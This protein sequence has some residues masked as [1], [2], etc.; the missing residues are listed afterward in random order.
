MVEVAKKDLVVRLVGT[1]AVN[2]AQAAQ[3]GVTGA[4]LVVGQ[5]YGR[6][7]TERL[8]PT[9]HVHRSRRAAHGTSRP[10]PALQVS[11]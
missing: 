2:V 10:R 1:R 4:E 11:S 5:R 3:V 9:E 6:R 7:E 8:A